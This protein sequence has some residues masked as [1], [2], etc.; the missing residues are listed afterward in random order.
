MSDAPASGAAGTTRASTALPVIEFRG[1]D[2]SYTGEPVLAGGQLRGA[3]RRVHLRGGSQRGRQ[4]HPAAPDPGHRAPGGRRS[5][6]VRRLPRNGPAAGWATCP[7]TPASTPCSRSPSWTWCAWAGWATSLAG[8]YRRRGPGGGR[9]GA[10]HRRAGRAAPAALLRPVRRAAAAGAHRPRPGHPSRAAAA[11]RAHGQRGPRGHRE[12]LRSAGGA[13]PPPHHPAGLARHRGGVP[14]RERGAVRQPHRVQ[15]PGEPPDRGNVERAVRRRHR[16]GAPRSRRGASDGLP[17]RPVAF[18]VSAVRPGHR[19]AGLRRLRGGGQLRHRAPDR[20]HRRGHRPHRAGRHGP[21]PLPAAR[22]GLGVRH[23]PG[24]RRG[25]GPAVGDHHR[26]GHPVR[27]AARGHGPQ[28][29]LVHRHGRGHLLHLAHPRLQRR[30]DELPVRQH[31]DGAPRRP[32]PDRRAGRP[33]RAG[34]LPVLLQAGGRLLRR[35]VRPPARRAGG[36]VLHAAALPHRPDHRD[37]AAGRR[38]S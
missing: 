31:P 2:F 36:A 38:A 25:L 20:L 34:E 32:G 15:A 12:A 27:P 1:V 6:G 24:R 29:G 28:R 11:G 10:G 18:P 13:G 23:A 26:G 17:A 21:G 5:A 35:G 8:P 9:G 7:S 30:S 4:D 33:G 16:P 37:P 19:P 3:A 22:A 14:V